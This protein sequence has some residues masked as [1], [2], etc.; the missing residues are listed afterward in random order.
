MIQ[1]P[2]AK[3]SR[4]DAIRDGLMED[5]G[6]GRLPPGAALEEGDLARRFGT[7]RTPVREALQ[8]LQTMGLVRAQPRKGFSVLPLTP[9]NLSDM[10]EYTAEIEATAARF[11]TYRITAPERASLEEIHENSKVAIEADNIED[12]GP[13]NIQFHE[14]IFRATHN[15]FL[16]E[17]AV[18]LRT[19]LLPFRRVQL[20]QHG[21][22]TTSF[23][24]HAGILRAIARGDGE[25][26]ARAMRE[27]VLD[28]STAL[29][30]YLAEKN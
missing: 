26:A 6:T 16:L 30:R 3:F 28:S 22:L 13:F 21:R 5:I 29:I 25:E 1:T 8:Q 23:Q 27:H 14:A 2:P 9:Q 10:F 20:H 4:A 15:P 11:A 7:S 12:Y 19:R 18:A 24:Q 17:Q